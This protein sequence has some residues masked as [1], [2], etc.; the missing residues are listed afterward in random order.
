MRHAHEKEL[1]EKEYNELSGEAA[2]A[3]LPAI[4]TGYEEEKTTMK[5]I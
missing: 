3:P 4:N 5:S 2:K 1:Q